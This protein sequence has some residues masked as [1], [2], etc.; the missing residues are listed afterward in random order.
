MGTGAGGPWDQDWTMR[1]VRPVYSLAVDLL[2]DDLKKALPPLG[3]DFDLPFEAMVVRARFVDPIGG[4]SWYPIQFDGADLFF[5]IV[6]SSNLAFAGQFT[7]RELEALGD[8][9]DPGRRTIQHDDSFQ[10]VEVREL[11]RRQPELAQVLSRSGLG[12]VGLEE[13]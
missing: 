4:W 7:L 12:L 1:L 9:E 5:G 11:I 2:T 8:P 13:S 6:A 3:S 10:P